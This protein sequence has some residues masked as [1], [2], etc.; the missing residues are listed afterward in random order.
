MNEIQ[1]YSALMF[2]AG[3]ALTH[4]VFYFD[5]KSKNKRFFIYLSASILQVLE[6]INLTH[7]ASIDYMGEQLKNVEESQRR[8]YLE[9][10]R[11]KLAA[12]M[13]LYVLLFR[14]SVPPEGRKFVNF[15]TWPEAKALIDKLK[16]FLRD[17]QGKG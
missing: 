15:K 4:A 12:L 16:G 6:N 7:D 11:Q 10:E 9:K 14:K 17:E 1:I 5:K 2:F 13:E 3:V 8:D